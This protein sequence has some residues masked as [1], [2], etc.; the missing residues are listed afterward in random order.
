MQACGPPRPTCDRAALGSAAPSNKKSRILEYWGFAAP[1][2]LTSESSFC[3]P[4]TSLRTAAA[5]RSPK[6]PTPQQQGVPLGTGMDRSNGSHVRTAK[7]CAVL[8]TTCDRSS[9]MVGCRLSTEYDHPEVGSP[10][11]FPNTPKLR[12]MIEILHYP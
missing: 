3:N 9:K 7:C 4:A 10:V 8:R 1:T 11:L 5:K 6:W 2:L 12:L